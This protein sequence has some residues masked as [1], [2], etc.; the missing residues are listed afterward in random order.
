M[1][2]YEAVHWQQARCLCTKCFWI[3]NCSC[4]WMLWM[5]CFL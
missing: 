5:W 4:S 3:F 2:I 1:V